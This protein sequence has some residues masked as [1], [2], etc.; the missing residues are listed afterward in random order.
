MKCKVCGANYDSRLNRCP[1]CMSENEIQA[2]NVLDEELKACE[3][4]TEEMIQKLPHRL[5]MKSG[6][7][8]L[9][10]IVLVGIVC[11]AFIC[12]ADDIF[13]T[14]AELQEANMEKHKEK[15]ERHL[16]DQ[17]YE[18]LY[19]YLLDHSLY[20]DGYEKYR[21]VEEVYFE[22]RGFLRNL[23]WISELQKEN[24]GDEETRRDAIF[25]TLNDAF[26]C[27]NKARKGFSDLIPRRNEEHLE[28]LY[29]QVVEELE[30]FGFD[31]VFCETVS[32]WKS[33]NEEDVREYADEV[34]LMFFSTEE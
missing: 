20:G 27:L 29:N 24:R 33:V 5:A 23:E 6:S 14:S 4:E 25:Y 12:F 8:I 18:A 22:Y 17:D 11:G 34:Y 21:E 30:I 26:G 19:D 9:T 10:G 3:Q 7:L 13:Q 31:S 1:F 28:Y 32:K 15:M 2:A 16:E